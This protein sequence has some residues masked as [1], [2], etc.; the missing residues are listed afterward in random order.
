[1][2]ELGASWQERPVA[3]PYQPRGHGVQSESG[4]KGAKV[5]SP[6]RHDS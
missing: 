2:E 1:M 3:F 6:L 4:R 5:K